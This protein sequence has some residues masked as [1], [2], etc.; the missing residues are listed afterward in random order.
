[1]NNL[2]EIWKENDTQNANFRNKNSYINTDPTDITK[3]TK[4][5]QFYANREE[6]KILMIADSNSI[7]EDI[8]TS[9]VR[10]NIK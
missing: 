4:M 10:K 1:M 2:H 8:L 3:I 9:T 5:W 6:G 7:I